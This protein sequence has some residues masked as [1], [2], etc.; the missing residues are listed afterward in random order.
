MK[1]K[2]IS[3][4]HRPQA[5]SHN[6]VVFHPWIRASAEA[7]PVTKTSAEQG[8]STPSAFTSSAT[9]QKQWTWTHQLP[10]LA[11]ARAPGWW[12]PRSCFEHNQHEAAAHGKRAHSKSAVICCWEEKIKSCSALCCLRL[13]DSFKPIT[14]N[15]GTK[16]PKADPTHQPPHHPLQVGFRQVQPPRLCL[17]PQLGCKGCV[18]NPKLQGTA[19]LFT[20][21]AQGSPSKLT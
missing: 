9:A 5:G 4:E 1:Q 21:A 14:P 15:S 18:G 3:A 20:H 16:F 19:L 8:V 2:R 7:L 17:S 11:P 13:P 12:N 6:R 10:E